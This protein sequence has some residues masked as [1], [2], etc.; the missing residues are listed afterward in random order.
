MTYFELVK[1]LFVIV[2]SIY[3]PLICLKFAMDIIYLI[4]SNV[5]HKVSK[6]ISSLLV[7]IFF[8]ALGILC[9]RFSSELMLS[10]CGLFVFLSHYVIVP[11][12]KGGPGLTFINLILN[13]RNTFI[14]LNKIN[15]AKEKQ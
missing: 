13:V 15:S 5:K 11:I 6:I 2:A 14:I 12:V 8:I 1:K 10:I 9:V 7:F 4:Y 3:L